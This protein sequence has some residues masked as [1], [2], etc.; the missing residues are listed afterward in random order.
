[1][2][3][4]WLSALR[5]EIMIGEILKIAGWLFFVIFKFIWAP[6]TMA[7]TTDYT[8][9]EILVINIVGAWLGIIIFFYFGKMIVS[10][11]NRKRKRLPRRFT[12]LNRFIIRVKTKWG[13]TGLVSIMGIISVPLCSLIAA[14]YFQ[15]NKRTVPA[16]L[17]SAVI[18]AAS[19]TVIVF[20]LLKDKEQVI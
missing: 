11:F 2:P 20:L 9:W 13:L 15:E 7:T 8:W 16:L 3:G 5:L 12:R 1:M 18:W 14:A 4:I 10:F 17:T 6:V 19:L